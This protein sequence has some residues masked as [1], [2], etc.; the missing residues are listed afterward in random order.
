MIV[1]HLRRCEDDALLKLEV[2]D[3]FRYLLNRGYTDLL[4]LHCPEPGVYTFWD[5]QGGAWAKDH[6][7]R[8]DHMLASPEIADRCHGCW[9]DHKRR[10]VERASDHVPLICDLDMDEEEKARKS[11][12]PAGYSVLQGREESE[13]AQGLLL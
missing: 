12:P 7:L 2:R 5:Y 6:G 9:V 13:E 11:D 4:R 8:I 3:R 10:G 1:L